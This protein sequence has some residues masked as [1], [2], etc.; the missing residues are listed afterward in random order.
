MKMKLEL[1]KCKRGY[2]EVLDRS[3]GSVV[4]TGTVAECREF[5][6]DT[7]KNAERSEIDRE[8]NNALPAIC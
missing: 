1:L 8:I 7:K 2:A 4:F 6:R 5:V 3:S